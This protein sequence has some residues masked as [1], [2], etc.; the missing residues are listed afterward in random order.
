VLTAGAEYLAFLHYNKSLEVI[1]LGDAWVV[2][3]GRVKKADEEELGFRDGTPIDQALNRLR[4]TYKRSSRYRR[5]DHIVPTAVLETL[6]HKTGWLA[7][8]ALAADRDVW[9][10]G[11]RDLRPDERPFDVVPD[12]QPARNVPRAKD[13]IRL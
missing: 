1:S 10:D 4:E 12:Q 11:Q 13:R 7:I 6:H 9:T 5:Y 3:D 8:G 2:V